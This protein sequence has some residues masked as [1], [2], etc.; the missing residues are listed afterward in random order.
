MNKKDVKNMLISMRTPQNEEAVNNLLG[1]IDLMEESKIQEIIAQLGGSEEAVRKELSERIDKMLRNEQ[2]YPINDMFT[3]GV[4]GNSIHLH[5]PGNLEHMM[6]KIGASKT[7]D[8][9]NL[10]LLDAIEKIA[11][12]RADGFYRFQGRDSIYMISPVLLR[13]ELTFLEGL[14]FKTQTYKKEELSDS[15]FLE[16]HPEARLANAIFGASRKVGTALI[17]IDKITTPEWQAKKEEVVQKFSKK[18]IT[19]GENHRTGGTP[20]Q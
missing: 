3:Y 8:T 12:M 18:G 7:V 13:R 14:D 2:K 20:E 1:K 6:S 15:K 4:S 19:M 17:E 16:E 10:Y 9:V 11:Q 5:L